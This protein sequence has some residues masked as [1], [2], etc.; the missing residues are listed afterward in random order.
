MYFL[1]NFGLD[2]H[3]QLLLQDQFTII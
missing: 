3:W 1:D 2:E